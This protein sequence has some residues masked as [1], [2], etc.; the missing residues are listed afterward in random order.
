M[1]NIIQAYSDSVSEDLNAN[2]EIQ[3]DNSS[4]RKSYMSHNY[5]DGMMDMSL[6]C[7]CINV[8]RYLEPCKKMPNNYDYLNMCIP[9]ILE[10]NPFSTKK[11]EDFMCYILLQFS[12]GWISSNFTYFFIVQ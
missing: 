9:Y 2:I 5:K 4:N 11:N 3:R 12:F 1:C 10:W 6:I 7:I 8:T